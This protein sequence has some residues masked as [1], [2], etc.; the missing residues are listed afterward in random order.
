M[1][2]IRASEKAQLDAA[3]APRDSRSGDSKADRLPSEGDAVIPLP[4]FAK[5]ADLASRVR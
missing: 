2:S 5:S 1:G 3:K 4:R